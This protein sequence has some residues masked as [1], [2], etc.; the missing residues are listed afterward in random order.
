[1]KPH[2]CE[3]DS[4]D[5]F[6]FLSFIIFFLRCPIC[7]A[8]AQTID[9]PPLALYNKTITIQLD[10]T[11]KLG[12]VLCVTLSSKSTVKIKSLSVNSIGFRQGLRVNDTI[13]CINS[14]PCCSIS[15][16]QQL[17]VHLSKTSVHIQIF[18]TPVFKWRWF[19]TRINGFKLFY[20]YCILWSENIWYIHIYSSFKHA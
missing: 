2:F 12:V 17:L 14:I 19:R 10:D 16:T 18:R 20:K 3:F 13:V 15:T 7:R 11:G 4:T 5:M 1:M 9:L 8:V 6:H